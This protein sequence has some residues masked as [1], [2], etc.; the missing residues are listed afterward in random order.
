MNA[1]AH[2]VESLYARDR[3]P[4]ISLMAADAI[5]ALAG[6]LPAI[7]R[8]PDDRDARSQALFGAWL[9]GVCLGSVGMALLCVPKIRF[10]IDAASG[11]R[12]LAFDD[13]SVQADCW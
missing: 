11:R 7:V 3:N 6:A 9:S 2:A 12:K 8:A 5:R 4:V 10:G 13:R 1:M